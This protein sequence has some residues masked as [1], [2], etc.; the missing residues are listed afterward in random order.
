VLSECGVGL[1][2]ASLVP[3][4]SLLVPELKM[5]KV[6]SYLF[7]LFILVNSSCAKCGVA[8][9]KVFKEDLGEVFVIYFVVLSIDLV[10]RF[11]LVFSHPC[12]TR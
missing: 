4:E 12:G 6:G 8:F 5:C 1:C 9:I 7:Y 11:D 2:L 3:V 10:L